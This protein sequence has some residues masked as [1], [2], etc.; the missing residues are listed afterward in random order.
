MRELKLDARHWTSRDDF[1]DAFF[2]AVGAP[3]WHGRNL[4]ALHDSIFTGQIND[5]EVP[6]R[7]VVEHLAQAPPAV[8]AF[9]NQVAGFIDQCAEREHCSVEMNII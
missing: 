9:V 6:Y 4:N 3:Q 2:S 5:V 8:S 1:Y 7:L